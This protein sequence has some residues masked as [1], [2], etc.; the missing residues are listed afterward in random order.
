VTARGVCVGQLLSA[1]AV[2]MMVV[3]QCSSGLYCVKSVD[4]DECLFEGRV[5]PQ[6]CIPFGCHLAAASS[7]A[8]PHGLIAAGAK[9]CELVCLVGVVLLCTA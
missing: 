3:V 9:W 8:L 5:C 6:D 1:R 7:W 4:I 2:V